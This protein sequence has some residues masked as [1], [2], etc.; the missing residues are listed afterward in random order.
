M[1]YTKGFVLVCCED[2]EDNRTEIKRYME[3]HK[4]TK[5]QVYMAVRTDRENGSKDLVLVVRTEV[6][7]RGG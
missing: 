7:I 2:T 1:R 4:L 3:R 5:E 6:D